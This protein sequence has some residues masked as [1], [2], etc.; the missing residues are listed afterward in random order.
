MRLFE[1]VILPVPIHL[2]AFYANDSNGC[3][4]G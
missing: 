1:R 4:G 2:C 3:N